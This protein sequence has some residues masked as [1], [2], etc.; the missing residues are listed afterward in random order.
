MARRRSDP[1]PS[2]FGDAASESKPDALEV[3]AADARARPQ[4]RA[5]SLQHVLQAVDWST[6][7]LVAETRIRQRGTGLCPIE[8]VLGRT[9]DGR[10]TYWHALDG[11]MDADTAN[12]LLLA[13]DGVDLE[14]NTRAAAVRRV[15][16]ERMDGAQAR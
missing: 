2:L 8:I 4:V 9:P 5:L 16:L 3:A 6:C 11:G 7:E 15:M 14:R 1:G 10:G 13:A 12:V